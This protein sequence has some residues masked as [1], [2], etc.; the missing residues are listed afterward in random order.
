[1]RVVCDIET[2]GLDNPQKIWVI[3][4][5][6]IDTGKSYTFRYVHLVKG[7][8]LEFAKGVTLWV[9][10]N[11]IQFDREVLLAHLGKEFEGYCRVD[12]TMDTLVLSRLFNYTQL[13]GHSLGN[14]G[15]IMGSPKGVFKDFS[16]YSKEMEDYCQQDCIV[17]YGIFKHLEKYFN[18]PNWVNAIKLE[19]E[20]TFIL[21]KMS[22]TGFHFNI[23]KAKEYLKVIE[24]KLE[25]VLEELHKVFP[26]KPEGIR[27]ITPQLT[28]KGT[29]HKKDFKWLATEDRS[30]G[31]E[32][33]ISM[34]TEGEPFTLIQWIPFNPNSTKQIIDR[35]VNV[36]WKP[37]EKTKGYL[38]AEREGNLEKIDYYTVYGWKVN[39]IN[40][41]TVPDDAPKEI[42]KLVGYITLTSRRSTLVEWIK[43]YNETTK[44]IHGS[45]NSVGSWTHRMSHS[46][47]N[48]ANIPTSFYPTDPKNLSFVD[49]VKMAYGSPFRALW[50]VHPE[51]E[52]LIG[53]D[54]EGIQL[55][56]L[57][58]YVNDP[59]FTHALV[60]GKKEDG[61]DAHTLNQKALG[62]ICRTRDVA[63]TFIYAFLLG[64][65]IKK[66]ASILECSMGQAK[67]AV[68]QFLSS[69]AGLKSLKED[70]IPYDAKKGF[71]TGLDNR[72]IRCD[73]THLMLAG[74]LQSGES[75]IMKNAT[76][77]WN[78][79]LTEERIPYKLINYVHDEWQT[80]TIRDIEIA[81]HIADVQC[82]S[83]RIVGEQLQLNC[84][85]AGNYKADKGGYTIGNNWSETH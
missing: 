19:H 57:A 6:D 7:P 16:R 9:G 59:I 27:E 45:F 71:F 70:K 75:I 8:F 46:Q 42:S 43:N 25:E 30:L 83:L 20:V 53:V 36:G 65:G 64:A 40:L 50:Q 58:H 37:I 73:S 81:K 84:P 62:S 12:N 24:K 33:D 4:C 39:E 69:W 38:I 1:M 51:Y 56:V 60:Y 29:L 79:Q 49:E 31:T 11:F 76:V 32:E 55:R 23:D 72:L 77:L 17:C 14:W 18:K 74:Y 63:K 44:N 78:K 54:A 66:L 47:P 26:P 34:Y 35:L 3:V 13:K 28:S 5:H 61:T 67:D 82:E 21:A 80:K 85:M 41:S 10:H 2:E 15:K 48:M 68:D 52:Y 22:T